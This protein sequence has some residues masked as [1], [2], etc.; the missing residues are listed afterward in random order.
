M[1][2]PCNL[3]LNSIQ[4][5]TCCPLCFQIGGSSVFKTRQNSSSSASN[6]LLSR[7]FR[8]SLC[9]ELAISI[10]NQ[11]LCNVELDSTISAIS[12]KL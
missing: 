3:V 4:P 5:H 7:Y 1:S 9:N 11:V 6:F 12:L 10:P 2:S 8:C